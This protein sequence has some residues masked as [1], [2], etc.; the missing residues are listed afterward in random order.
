MD[1]KDYRNQQAGRTILTPTGFWVFIPNQ[2]P[3][4]ITWTLPLVSVLSEAERDLSRLAALGGY[5]S[6][7]TAINS[8]LY[9]Q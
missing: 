5:F 6:I 3:P 7:S 8:T 4:D 1:P 9:P 2:L